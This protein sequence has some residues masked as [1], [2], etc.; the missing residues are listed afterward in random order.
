MADNLAYVGAAIDQVVHDHGGQR[1]VV[2]AGFSQGVAM[3]FRAASVFPDRVL[4]VVAVGG[5][6]P[7]ELDRAALARV[8]HV[9]LMRGARDPFY[10]VE[11]FRKDQQ[12]LH[13]AAVH[14]TPVEFDGAHDW[15]G[16]VVD[17]AAG[18][19]KARQP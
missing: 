3:A 13:D 16:P 17:A 5:D 11:M 9:L 7:P 10:S 14:L 18:F 2:F 19:L 12:R 15:P 4:G 8:G 6:V 1:A